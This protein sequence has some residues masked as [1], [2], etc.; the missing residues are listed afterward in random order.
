MSLHGCMGE[1]HYFIIGEKRWWG[2]LNQG[3][4]EYASAN[5]LI[6]IYP[7]A[8]MNIATNNMGCWDD[9]G[10]TKNT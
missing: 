6:V 2:T 1:V 4:N 7:Q 8:R 5:D 10:F 9:W 3:F